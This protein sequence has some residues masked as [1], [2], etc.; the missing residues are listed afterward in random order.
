MPLPFAASSIDHPNNIWWKLNSME[1]LIIYLFPAFF[2]IFP[3]GFNIILSICF[4]KK[5]ALSNTS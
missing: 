3:L 4:S 2:Y 1:F 5:K